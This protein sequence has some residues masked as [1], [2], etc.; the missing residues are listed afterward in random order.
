MGVSPPSNAGFG[1]S[2]VVVLG[3]RTAI[4]VRTMLAT[5]WTLA[6]QEAR[7]GPSHHS[8]RVRPGLTHVLHAKALPG[9]RRQ[10]IDLNSMVRTA[11]SSGIKVKP[12]C[13]KRN[14]AL[15]HN[16]RHAK[17]MLLRQAASAQSRAIS[18]TPGSTQLRGSQGCHHP[19]ACESSLP[20]ALCTRDA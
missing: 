9:R 2:R 8:D 7:R 10:Q 4:K 17:T 11:A 13:R 16:L 6:L 12:A 1:S 20:L 3:P 18:T 19:L 15:W 14:R 5:S